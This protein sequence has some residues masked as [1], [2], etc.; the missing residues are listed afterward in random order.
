MHHPDIR[1]SY[2]EPNQIY[3]WTATINNWQPLLETNNFKDVIIESLTYLSSKKL[4]DVFGFVVMPNHIHLIWRLNSKNGKEPPSASLL[5]FTA[6]QFKKML[7]LKELTSYLVNAPNK[8][9]E[10]WQRDSKA[11]PLWTPK[12][13]YQKLDYIHN[14][15]VNGKWNLANDW[16]DYHYSS[17]AYY[18]IGGNDFGFLKHLGNEF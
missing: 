8:A 2:I 16:V 1:K 18:E 13:A 11:T 10:F 5:K 17:G 12:V 14:N 3:F 15:P 7:D 6:H 4:I 9:H